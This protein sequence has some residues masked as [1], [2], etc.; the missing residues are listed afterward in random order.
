M[1]VRALT[2]VVVR[3]AY[4]MRMTF[5]MTTTTETVNSDQN[6]DHDIV[7]I[8]DN[9]DLDDKRERIGSSSY[10]VTRCVVKF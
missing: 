5:M 1:I 8:E 7:N 2:V 9:H 4:E 6:D 3:V 10:N